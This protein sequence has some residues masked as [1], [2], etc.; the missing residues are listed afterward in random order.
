[1]LQRLSQVSSISSFTSCIYC[2]KTQGF[3]R[4]L[5]DNV[6][7]FDIVSQT[8][9]LFQHKRSFSKNSHKAIPG[10]KIS[11]SG[12]FILET[13]T[14]IHLRPLNP[15]ILHKIQFGVR[16]V[17]LSCFCRPCRND[18]RVVLE[19]TGRHQCVTL[20]TFLFPD[21]GWDNISQLGLYLIEVRPS[22]SFRMHQ[23]FI[24]P[25]EICEHMSPA[26]N[27]HLLIGL[28]KMWRN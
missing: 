19:F 2:T 6:K 14:T 28:L 7:S 21:G 10:G 8:S 15:I 26:P 13:Y 1:M 5:V 20:N 16:H 27:C 17:L 4:P 25:V 11:Y 18:I 23:E 9:S 22:G 3:Y 12:D 24:I